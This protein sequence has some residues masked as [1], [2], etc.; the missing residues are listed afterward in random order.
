MYY[1]NVI[2]WDAVLFVL[3]GAELYAIN[4]GFNN[5]MLDNYARGNFWPDDG[6]LFPRFA[7]CR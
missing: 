1:V 6:L 5:A 3:I 2:L 7:L 4:K